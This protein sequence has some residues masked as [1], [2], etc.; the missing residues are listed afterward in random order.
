MADITVTFTDAD[1]AMIQNFA[2]KTKAN[3]DWAES[4]KPS[5]FWSPVHD[6]FTAAAVML[7]DKLGYTR[8]TLYGSGDM[9]G[10]SSAT[11]GIA[12]GKTS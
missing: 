4:H 9:T 6:N 12:G 7:E 3:I 10:Y 11:G 1:Q 5:P 8:G 2:D